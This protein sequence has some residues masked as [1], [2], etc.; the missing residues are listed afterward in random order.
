[1]KFLFKLFG[2]TTKEDEEAHERY[3]NERY[4]EAKQ[5]DLMS[6]I[7][8]V[9]TSNNTYKIQ[10]CFSEYRGQQPIN[11]SIARTHC[12]ATE[13]KEE[14]IRLYNIRLSGER[15]KEWVEV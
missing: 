4:I 12:N 10:R 5:S 7:K 2:F 6:D 8:L 3:V 14:Y 13:G 9:L 11:P 15:D 1:M